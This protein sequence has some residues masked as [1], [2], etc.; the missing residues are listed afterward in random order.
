MKT[1]IDELSPA[2]YEL[3]NKCI[4]WHVR[5]FRQVFIEGLATISQRLRFENLNILELGATARSTLS[6]FLVS[7]GANTTVTCYSKGEI[8]KL[9]ETLSRRCQQYGLARERFH[10][11]QADIFALDQNARFD[12]VLLKGVLGGVNRQHDQAEF[13]KAVS[14]CSSILNPNGQLMIIDKARS[15]K[16]IHWII[17][18]L[19]KAGKNEWHYFTFDELKQLIPSGF[20]KTSL[21]SHGV[22]SF[23]DF[24]GGICQN[25]AD[26]L[27]EHYMERLVPLEKRGVFSLNCAA[28]APG[29]VA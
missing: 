25:V 12:L 7:R 9:D 11:L 3:L 27:D 15:L 17:R 6:P 18:R 4:A 20:V 13:R 29:T 19:G 14:N 22:L 23:G 10:I 5:P 26:Y 1:P 21:A 8:S 28:K 16:V 24:G 2:E